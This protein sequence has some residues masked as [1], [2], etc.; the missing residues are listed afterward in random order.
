MNDTI[1]DIQ[2][3]NVIYKT[4]L[5]TVCA[6]NGVN[7]QLKKGQTL[8]LVGETG[9]GK[10]TTA[11]SIMR[12]LPERVGRITKG[13]ICF[14]GDDI[15]SISEDEM[16]SYRGNRIAMIF[17]DPMTSLNPVMTVGQQIGEAIKLHMDEQKENLQ[18][19][20]D[21]IL[22]I[23]G[24]PANRKS[25]YPHQF[26]GGMKQR[27]VIAMALSCNP[28][29]LIADEP[30]TALDVTI[31]AQILDMMA[32]LKKSFSTSMIL[33]THDLAVVSEIC[34]LVSVMYAGEIIES[35]TIS[36]VFSPGKHH[37]YTEGLFQSIPSLTEVSDRLH[38]I[39]G[40]MPDPTKLP[41]GCKFH[42]RCKFR[43]DQCAHQ[44][45]DCSSSGTH[46]VK[47]HLFG[48]AQAEKE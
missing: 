32:E 10:T 17:Q 30:T 27:V 6:V 5:E 29:L 9:A 2:N 35:G 43:T 37:P 36:D 38:P 28:E 22:E 33:I 18:A 44:I 16:R 14:T 40:L 25:E 21:K 19:R 39:D 8:G 34:D 48:R 7:I 1:L 45:P 20:V 46:M 41:E 13:S 15:T 24:I 26:S 12:L 31:Q 3:L 47:C 42:P 23:V 11:L 4:D